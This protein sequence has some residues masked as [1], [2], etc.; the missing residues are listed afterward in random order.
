MVNPRVT[1]NQETW[2]SESSLDLIGKGTRGETTSNGCGSSVGCILKDGPLT[3]RTC[4]NDTDIRWVLD[5]Y[6]DTC[7]QEKLLIGLLQVD[8]VNT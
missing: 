2:L 1:D 4:R 6:N 7:S 3:I 8:E 5:G